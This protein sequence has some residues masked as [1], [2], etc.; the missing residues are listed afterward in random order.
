MNKR[1]R[2]NRHGIM[3]MQ[4][5]AEPKFQQV[6]PVKQ[7]KRKPFMHPRMCECRVCI[8]EDVQQNG[9]PVNEVAVQIIN[10]IRAKFRAPQKKQHSLHLRTPI[11]FLVKEAI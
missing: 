8:R 2:M 9:R 11:R 3:V 4:A 7:R 6:R 1:T 5:Q 10:E